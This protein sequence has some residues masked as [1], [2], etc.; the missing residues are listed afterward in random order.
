MSKAAVASENWW[1]R[2]YVFRGIAV[3][4][5]RGA[6]GL[7]GLAPTVRPSSEEV[8]A[9]SDEW[10]AVLAEA[11]AHDPD[12][13]VRMAAGLPASQYA[14]ELAPGPFVVRHAP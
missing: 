14:A 6:A 5:E 7:E 4:L 12:G 13:S 1:D 2:F 10:R 9:A 11:A 3:T 8:L